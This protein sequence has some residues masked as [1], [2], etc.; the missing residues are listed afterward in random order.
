MRVAFIVGEFPVISETFIINQVADLLDRDVQVEVFSLKRGRADKVSER[1]SKYGMRHF[2]RYLNQPK[3]KPLR[4]AA[5][6]F[7]GLKILI[8]RP[9]L[10]MRALDWKKYGAFARSLK[11][12]FWIEPFIGKQ[13]D[14]VHC[15]FGT[16]ANK[17]LIMRDILG[18]QQKFITTFYGY[19]ISHVPHTKPIGYYDVLTRECSKFLVMSENM[20]GRAIR[21]G[22]PEEKITVH[23]ISI[24]VDSYPFSERIYEP[25][26]SIEIIS[27]GRFVEKKGFDD[28]LRAIALVKEKSSKKFKLSIVGDGPL[29]NSLY[30]LARE[31]KIEDVLEFKGYMKIQDIIKLFGKSHLYVQASKTSADGD[32]E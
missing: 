19:D 11:T 18:H 3:N 20:K 23:P 4:L 26:K 15:H 2:T 12:L 9:E 13:F 7:V 27:V 32:M 30:A 5:I 8:R 21:L 6:F 17:Y 29:R 25:R 1:F 28:L 10:L 16:I 31:L 24:D 14:L 22:I